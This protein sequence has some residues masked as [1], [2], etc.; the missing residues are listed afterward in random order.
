M[1]FFFA[2]NY[3]MNKP[4]T[5]ILNSIK[6][7]YILYRMCTTK[8]A[9]KP[10]KIFQILLYNSYRPMDKHVLT[11]WYVNNFGGDTIEVS[12]VDIDVGPDL[13]YKEESMNIVAHDVK[14]LRNKK[15]PSFL[16][17]VAKP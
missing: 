7:V 11:T 6:S 12:T 8:R 10:N 15:N 5:F 4:L 14:V 17:V 1:Q 3:F 2:W 9:H 16:S 13:S